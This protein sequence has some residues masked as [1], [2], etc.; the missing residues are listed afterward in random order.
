MASRRVDRL[1]LEGLSDNTQAASLWAVDSATALAG[2]DREAARLRLISRAVA[3]ERA[4]QVVLEA[5]LDQHLAARD[6]D[7][8]G[9]INKVL[10]STTKRTLC[11][12]LREHVAASNLGQRA[13]VMVGHADAVHVGSGK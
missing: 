3:T 1:A 6:F 10:S 9:A 7:A 11:A 8:V 13:T 4:R 12:L 2:P 5:L